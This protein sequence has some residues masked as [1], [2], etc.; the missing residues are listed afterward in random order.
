MADDP[1][2]T[3]R[4]A[5]ARARGAMRGRRGNRRRTWRQFLDD[6]YAPWATANR[7]SGALTVA[8]LRSRFTEF[9]A[10]L[11]ADL[12]GFTIERWRSARLKSGVK[13]ATCNRNLAALRAALSKAVEWTVIKTHPMADVKQSH[14]DK[15]EYLR[16]LDDAEETR[17][18][19]ALSA[20]DDRRRQERDSA[21]RW[22]RE[23]GYDEWPALGTYTDTL[24]PIVLTAIN[25]GL[26]FGELTA[27]EWRDIDFL[28]PQLTVRS[29]AAKSG[30]SRRVPLNVEALKT[31]SVWKPANAQ[32][33]DYVF[34]GVDGARLT[35]IKTAWA[36]LLKTAKITGFRFHDTRHHFASRLVMKGV[37]LNTVR[38]LLGHAD[39]KM[40]LRYAHLAPEHKAAA[41][42]KLVRA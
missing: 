41:V 38:E 17:L 34:P 32:A 9:D 27:L 15:I 29:G 18:R 40:T 36:P 6:H 7:K 23:R 31:L 19:A 37:D 33:S 8:S 5:K 24:T 11:L 22:R 25:T 28:L 20:R 26:R 2:L 13:P 42:A 39:I 21:N 14:E 16:Y 4:D 12:S 35:D 3:L 30:R 10:T 1:A